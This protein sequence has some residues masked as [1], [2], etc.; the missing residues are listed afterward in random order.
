MRDSGVKKIASVVG[1][2][3]KY[4]SL[5]I[6]FDTNLSGWE[7]EGLDTPRRRIEGYQYTGCL[8]KQEIVPLNSY[9]VYCS[10]YT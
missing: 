8:R 5:V 4:T 6:V 3:V 7:E 10:E 2:K 1:L 9:K